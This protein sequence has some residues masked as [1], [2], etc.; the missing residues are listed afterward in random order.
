MLLALTAIVS[1]VYS[2]CDSTNKK[3]PE[4]KILLVDSPNISSDGKIS[5]SQNLEYKIEIPRPLIE[6]SLELLQDFFINKGKSDFPG[7]N[8]V[9]VRVYL[10]GMSLKELPYASLL[11]IADKKEILITGSSKNA[12]FIQ[13]KLKGYT[14]LGCWIVYKEDSYIIC[15]KDNKFYATYINKEKQSIN[16]LQQLETKVKNGETVYYEPNDQHQEYMAIRDNGLYIYDET[17][18][19]GTDATIWSNDPMWKNN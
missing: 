5:P 19:L 4:Y 12:N 3:L 7:I 6:D 16:D 10:E 8:K 18:E 2:S 1:C 17:G 15:Q 13:E 9:I 11:L 14:V